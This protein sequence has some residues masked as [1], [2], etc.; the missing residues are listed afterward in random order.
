M[1][2]TVAQVFGLL[3]VL[4]GLWVAAWVSQWVGSHWQGAR[5]AVVF[6]ALRW[7]VAVL[8]GFAVAALFGWWGELLSKAI[9]AGVLG[10]L[11][12]LGGGV[13]GFALGVLIAALLILA[14]IRVPAL[15]SLGHDAARART[16]A[17]L[18]NVGARACVFEEKVFPG[19]GWL[20]QQFEAA[21]Y[22]A[23]RARSL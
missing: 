8:A 18:M 14:A 3:G 11:D 16:A 17:P 23:R 1:R 9:Q 7:T 22:R 19:R 20:R 21:E 6:L 4:F 10:W 5:P 2:G 12:R 15:A 13:V